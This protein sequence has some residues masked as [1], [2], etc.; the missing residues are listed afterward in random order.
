MDAFR[1]GFIRY[2]SKVNEN[3]FGMRFYERM[4]VKSRHCGGRGICHCL[5]TGPNQS[6]QSCR[7]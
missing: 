6:R 2:R 3:G 4:E 1:I 7:A 5:V